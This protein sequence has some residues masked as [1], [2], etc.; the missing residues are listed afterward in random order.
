MLPDLELEIK[1]LPLPEC[2]ELT[3]GL[4]RSESRNFE[5]SAPSCFPLD[6][7]IYKTQKEPKS[8]TFRQKTKVKETELYF[9]SCFTSASYSFLGA[10]PS[11]LLCSCADFNKLSARDTQTIQTFNCSA[12]SIL[13]LRVSTV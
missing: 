8:H 10:S 13:K 3:A 9:C 6:L 12:S 7:M 2:W 1:C 11:T 5:E 4:M